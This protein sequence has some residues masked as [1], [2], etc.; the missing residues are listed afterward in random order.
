MYVSNLALNDFRSYREVVLAFEPGITVFVGENGQGKTNLVEAIGYLS[1][2]SSHRVAAD[3]ALVRQGASAGVVRAK[4]VR[5]V[6]PVTLELEIIAGKANR[7]RIN[8]G[9]ARPR[10]L[11][12]LVRTVMFAPEDLELVKG[13][14]GDRRAFLD[15]LMV[16][17][18]P[19]LAA[20]KAEYEKVLR[21][22]GALLK[23]LQKAKRRGTEPDTSTLSVWDAQL[24]K[25][26]AQIVAARAEI[27]AGLR[28]FVADYYELVSGGK[29]HARIDYEANVD[30]RTGYT[31]PEPLQLADP[32]VANAVAEHEGALADVG[33]V[34]ELLTQALAEHRS[35]EIERGVNLV[36]PHR[37]D[38]RLTLGT[39]PAKGYASHGESWSYALALKLGM[40]RLL[41]THES[42]EWADSAEPILI[43]DDVFAELDSRRRERLAAIVA[44]A[45]QVFVTAAVGDDL[46]PSLA[47]ARFVVAG[48]T[49][50]SA[51]A[52]ARVA[53]MPA[54]VAGAAGTDG[55]V[56]AGGNFTRGQAEPKVEGA[57]ESAEEGD[58]DE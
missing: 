52:G 2:F 34:S 41:R 17:F 8:R 21:Q 37:D 22:R 23:H 4:V 50:T 58:G 35:A 46:P 25:F 48:G 32:A 9:N 14:P 26:G 55:V 49:V 57:S 6:S 33:A 24:V 40:W 28:P 43:L 53:S 7:A 51:D 5:G 11:L 39:L 15:D 18:R 30:K 13:D 54:D 36:G 12:G 56:S 44:H 16:Q 31:L 1:T 42:G 10:D 20:V 45:E 19:R 47:G 3:A 27:V 29:G 38:L